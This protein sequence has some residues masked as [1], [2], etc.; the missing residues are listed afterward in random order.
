M[1]KKVFKL[2]PREVAAR[3]TSQREIVL[4][5]QDALEVVDIMESKGIL[6]L[7]WEGWVQ[8]ADGRVGHGSAPQG[9]VSLEDLSVHE[10]AEVCRTTM[11]EDAAQWEKENQGSSKKLH[12]CITV[13][14]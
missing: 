14:A 6:I 4:P 3:S 10:A 7:G 12:F 5:L 8:T 2:L 11:T 9:T 1:S 13:R